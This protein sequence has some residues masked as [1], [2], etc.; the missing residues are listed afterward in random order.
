MHL[1]QRGLRLRKIF[2]VPLQHLL[3]SDLYFTI[4]ILYTSNQQDYAGLEYPT[5]GR[6]TR[7]RSSL[8]LL[9]TCT[10]NEPS[11][12]SDLRPYCKMVIQLS[13]VLN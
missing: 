2:I 3:N 7:L 12:D 6:K 1:L 13:L 4:K 5:R 9:F 8:I 11:T 10:L